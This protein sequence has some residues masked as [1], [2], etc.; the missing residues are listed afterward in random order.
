MKFSKSKN[1]LQNSSYNHFLQKILAT[2]TSK[3]S[4]KRNK[5]KA[6]KKAQ[7]EATEATQPQEA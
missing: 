1:N 7:A 2:S 5:K 4:K 6:A 3:K